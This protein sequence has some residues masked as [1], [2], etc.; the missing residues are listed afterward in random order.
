MVPWLTAACGVV[1]VLM[2]GVSMSRIVRRLVR[3]TAVAWDGELMHL[4]MAASMAGMLEGRF[5]LLPVPLWIAFFGVGAAWSGWRFG[6]AARYTVSRE[7]V[8]QTM[9]NLGGCGAMMY[10][11]VVVPQ[12]TNMAEMS[13]II[14]GARMLGMSAGSGSLTTPLTVLGLSLGVPLIVGAACLIF[15]LMGMPATAVAEPAPRQARWVA[16]AGVVQTR[17]S[18]T[19]ATSTQ[20]AMGVT[21]AVAL[22]AMYS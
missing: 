4:G 16:G 11:L 3:R 15:T 17:R 22:V 12:N 9:L 6:S 18:F 2:I 21:M 20:I 8:G 13:E 7:L 10:M 14:C 1:M 5:T 19:L